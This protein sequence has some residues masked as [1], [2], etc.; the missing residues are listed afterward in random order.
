M[1]PAEALWSA[2][3]ALNTYLSEPYDDGNISELHLEI[4]VVLEAAAPHMLAEARVAAWDEGV[5]AAK[6]ESLYLTTNVKNPY[7]GTA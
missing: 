7:R 6:L 3:R 4:L 1:I 2:A 5:H